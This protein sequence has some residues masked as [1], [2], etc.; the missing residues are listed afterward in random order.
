MKTI[1]DQ[2]IEMEKRDTANKLSLVD[3]MLISLQNQAPVVVPN[4]TTYRSTTDE[5]AYT[6]VG[7]NWV[8]ENES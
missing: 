2:G 8:S 6:K 5:L 1:N 7:D 3:K 4:N